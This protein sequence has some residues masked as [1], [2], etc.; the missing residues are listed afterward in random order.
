MGSLI[1]ELRRPEAVARAEAD[2]LRDLICGRLA[3]E[4]GWIAQCAVWLA[5]LHTSR[6]PGGQPV[7]RRRS[8]R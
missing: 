8:P 5:H 7:S 1:E 2:R 3:D 4:A 6:Y